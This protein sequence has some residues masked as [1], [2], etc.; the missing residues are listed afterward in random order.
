MAV[1]VAD[2]L[3]SLPAALKSWAVADVATWA[4]LAD[5]ATYTQHLAV[6]AKLLQW[7]VLADAATYTQHQAVA[8]KL[9][10]LL[11]AV[12]RSVACLLRSL[13][14][15]AVADAADVLL[16]Q[17]VASKLSA[18]ADVATWAVQADA[19]KYTQHLLLADARLVQAAVQKL[20]ADVLT[21]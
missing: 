6:A 17:L 8:A 2:V 14:S 7:A 5:A 4:V 10:L 12:Q 1:A 11:V 13:A 15:V 16:S 21:K 20:L 19:A 3:L 9:L 18:M